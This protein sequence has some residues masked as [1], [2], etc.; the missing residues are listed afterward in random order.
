MLQVIMHA[1]PNPRKGYEWEDMTGCHM[2][3]E[4]SSAY[5]RLDVY[6]DHSRIAKNIRICK[7]CLCKGEELINHEI[8]KQCS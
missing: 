4:I 1:V 6:Q 3:G 7:G 5:V 8:L 2:C